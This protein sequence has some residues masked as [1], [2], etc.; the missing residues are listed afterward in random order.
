MRAKGL[1][2]KLVEEEMFGLLVV[3]V[4]FAEISVSPFA[5]LRYYQPDLV[6]AVQ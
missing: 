4:E 2:F 5:L 1:I 3:G 6:S